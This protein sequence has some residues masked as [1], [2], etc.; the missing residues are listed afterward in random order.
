MEASKGRDAPT[1]KAIA[2]RAFENDQ[3]RS[4]Y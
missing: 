4:S 3:F 2:L 1:R